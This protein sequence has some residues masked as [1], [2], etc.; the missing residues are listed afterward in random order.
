MELAIEFG[1]LPWNYLYLPLKY[2]AD[3]DVEVH[4]TQRG[5]LKQLEH[6]MCSPACPLLWSTR[7]SVQDAFRYIDCNI[8]TRHG[9]NMFL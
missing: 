8:Q 3:L 7:R 6:L 5:G 1:N 4:G 2:G 9:H